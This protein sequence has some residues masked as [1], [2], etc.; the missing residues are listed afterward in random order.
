MRR[1]ILL[2]A[3]LSLPIVA[4]LPP[5]VTQFPYP[6]S[7]YDSYHLLVT[8]GDVLWVAPGLNGGVLRVEL[9]GR[10]EKLTI[11]NGWPGTFGGTTLGPDGA[12]WLASN[13]RIVRIDPVTNAM[14]IFSPGSNTTVSF[15][16][17]GADGHLWIR[18]G[19][20]SMLRMRTDG[21]VLSS[22][23]VPTTNFVNGMAP[24][25]DGAMYLTTIT[26]LVRVTESGEVRRFPAA[27]RGSL[28]AGSGFLWSTERQYD[29]PQRAPQSEIVKL[30]YTGETLGTYRLDMTA[31]HSD[32][33]GNLWLRTTTTQ[34]EVVAQLSPAGV[35]TKYGPFPALGATQCWP[36]HYGGLGT[37]SDGR[38]VMAD[39]YPDIPDTTI[40]PCFHV[41]K[42]DGFENTITILDPRIAPVMSVEPLGRTSRRRSSRP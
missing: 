25:S 14:Q 41:P 35:L 42:P 7:L 22:V 26:E 9:D 1:A 20:G 19:G 40:S 32:A 31:L 37:L 4:Q 23:S 33:Q 13:S 2:S 24:G 39:Y 12:V 38:V 17:T 16:R 30:S 34:G 15:L 28:H 36:R 11:P 8:P 27:P 10:A 21:A 29:A 3:L 5:G 6:E 18:T